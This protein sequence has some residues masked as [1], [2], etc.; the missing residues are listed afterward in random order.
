MA[1]QATAI[2]DAKA[3]DASDP[4]ASG[5]DARGQPYATEDLAELMR[6]KADEGLLFASDC[7]RYDDCREDAEQLPHELGVVFSPDMANVH[8]AMNATSGPVWTSTTPKTGA[9][10]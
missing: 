4:V 3:Q 9:R 1:R 8:E 6:Q 7:P 5:A 10:S 2:S